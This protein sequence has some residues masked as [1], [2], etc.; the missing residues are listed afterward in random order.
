MFGKLAWNGHTTG[1]EA[2]PETFELLQDNV[3]INWLDWQKC[4]TLNQA[5]SDAAGELTLYRRDRRSGNTSI[6]DL[7]DTVRAFGENPSTPFTIPTVSLDELF[8]GRVDFLK[9]DVEGAEPLVMRGA[10]RMITDNPDISIVMEWSPGQIA[11]AGF[12]PVA[13]TQSLES[14]GLGAS[15][16]HNDGTQTPVTWDEVRAVAYGNLLMRRRA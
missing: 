5:V 14:L 13:F 7:G 16:M 9:V 3:A 10:A 2:D 11:M 6:A 12:D 1:F 8:P 15:A 4:T